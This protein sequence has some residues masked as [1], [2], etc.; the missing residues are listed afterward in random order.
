MKNYILGMVIGILS[1]SGGVL[2]IIGSIV[3]MPQISS[4]FNPNLGGILFIA[5]S[6]FFFICDLLAAV[7]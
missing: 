2:F 6:S 3:Y 1:C 5:G 4:N 7:A